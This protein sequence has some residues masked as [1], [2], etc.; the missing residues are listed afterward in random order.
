MIALAY[1]SERTRKA[2]YSALERNNKDIEITDW[3][4]YFAETIN[5]AQA[6]FREGID[7]FRGDLSAENYIT[8]TKTS[9]AT[10]TRDLQ[11]LIKMG[12]VTKTG[13]LRHTRYHLN[14]ALTNDGA[15][16][17]MPTS[18]APHRTD[19]QETPAVP[20]AHRLGVAPAGLA[21]WRAIRNA[22]KKG[23]DK[24]PVFAQSWKRIATLERL[25]QFS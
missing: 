9:R 8:I 24:K 7:G 2:Y 11:V 4:V 6:I 15:R 1:T 18:T 3:L 14:L 19:R 22:I 17:R 5:Q 10:G 13:E 12:A 20:P 16:C 23:Q 21:P 25:F